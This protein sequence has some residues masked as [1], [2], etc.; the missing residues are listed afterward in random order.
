[1]GGVVDQDVDA[2][3]TLGDVLDQGCH[4]GVIRDVA[5]E[6]RGVRLIA[7]G[8]IASDTLSLVTALHIHDG[9]MRAFFRKRMAN[10]LPETA[11]ATGDQSYRAAQ[12]HA[13]S[14]NIKRP[15]ERAPSP[16]VSPTKSIPA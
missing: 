11:I 14:P 16:R 7:R 8:Q 2:A 10:P 6:S 5:G 3:K 15:A 1:V 4:S 13:L 12:L 9:D